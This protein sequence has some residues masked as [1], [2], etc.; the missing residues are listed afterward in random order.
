MSWQQLKTGLTK[1]TAIFNNIHASAVIIHWIVP[2]CHFSRLGRLT[3]SRY[4]R[5][6]QGLTM[7]KLASDSCRRLKGHFI[8]FYSNKGTLSQ[9]PM[10]TVNYMKLCFWVLS[11]ALIYFGIPQLLQVPTLVP[12]L[13][14]TYILSSV[15]AVLIHIVV[16]PYKTLLPLPSNNRLIVKRSRF[17]QKESPFEGSA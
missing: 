13:L 2:S 5:Q 14:Q 17:A 16:V 12:I 7:L 8:A 3:A 6:L 1:V 15:K 10:N 4:R 9:V 11:E